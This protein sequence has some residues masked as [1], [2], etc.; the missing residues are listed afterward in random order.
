MSECEYEHQG[1]LRDLAEPAY[2]NM[3][4]GTSPNKVTLIE[5]LAAL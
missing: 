3:Y 4:I 1:A 2:S 5:R